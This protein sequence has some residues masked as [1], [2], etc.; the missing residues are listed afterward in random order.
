MTI[1]SHQK[2]RNVIEYIVKTKFF[3]FI[4]KTCYKN[5]EIMVFVRILGIM[6]TLSLY[7]CLYVYVCVCICVFMLCVCLRVSV[8]EGDLC[9]CFFVYVLY[10]CMSLCVVH[11]WVCICRC[12]RV[13]KY[14]WVVMCIAINFYI[15]KII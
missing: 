1:Q 2:N 8:R 4:I 9:V 10:I 13:C 14:G 3:C 12:V 15:G 5:W 7:V 6:P 11:F